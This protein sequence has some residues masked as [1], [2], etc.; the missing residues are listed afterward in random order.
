L[1]SE[2][3]E[4]LMDS[5]RY[6]IKLGGDDGKVLW[7][8]TMDTEAHGWNSAKLVIDQTGDVIVSGI[9]DD[10][11]SLAKLVINQQS[12]F[13]DSGYLVKFEGTDGNFVW[14]NTYQDYNNINSSA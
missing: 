1:E 14:A 2:V 3:Q 10:T 12:F 8:R 11:Q 5:N 13:M 4:E 7:H 9:Y 6:V